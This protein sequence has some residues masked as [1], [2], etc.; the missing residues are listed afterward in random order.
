MHMKWK[1]GRTLNGVRDLCNGNPKLQLLLG[2]EWKK[3]SFDIS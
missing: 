3:K 1:V 2:S